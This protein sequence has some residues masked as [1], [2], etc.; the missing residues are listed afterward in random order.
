MDY[1]GV[2][3]ERAAEAWRRPLAALLLQMKSTYVTGG[4]LRHVHVWYTFILF[5]MHVTLLYK[6]EPNNLKK[7]DGKRKKGAGKRICSQPCRPVLPATPGGEG[8]TCSSGPGGWGA[9]L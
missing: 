1:N 3:K 5:A 2:S 7:T 4:G 9:K 8:L 6:T